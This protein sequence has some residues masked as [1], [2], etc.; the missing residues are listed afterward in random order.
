MCVCV[1][2]SVHVCVCLLVCAFVV[3]SCLIVQLCLVFDLYTE[4]SEC[5]IVCVHE[6]IQLTASKSGSKSSVLAFPL[7]LF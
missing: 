5:V 7:R 3:R 2:V 6:V 1:L 4:A